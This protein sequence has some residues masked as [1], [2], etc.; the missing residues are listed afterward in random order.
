VGFFCGNKSMLH[1]F[2]SVEELR[3]GTP[4]PSCNLQLA[5]AT[6]FPP[7]AAR[8][9]FAILAVSEAALELD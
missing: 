7:P 6:P 1:F 5:T 2:A 9:Q 4:T 8:R 3:A